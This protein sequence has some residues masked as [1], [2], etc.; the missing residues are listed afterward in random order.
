MSEKIERMKAWFKR[1]EQ[2]AHE[3][4]KK[5]SARIT[6]IVEDIAHRAH[7]GPDGKPILFYGSRVHRRGGLGQPRDRIFAEKMAIPKTRKR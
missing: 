1:E 6:E 3:H 7:K 4:H 5:R 2:N